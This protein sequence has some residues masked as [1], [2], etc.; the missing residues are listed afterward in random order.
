MNLGATDISPEIPTEPCRG[1]GPVAQFYDDLIGS[2]L[3][4]FANLC[5]VELLGRI[6]R[7]TLFLELY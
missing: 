4:D 2:A 7:E 1:G 6:P 3:E 5:R